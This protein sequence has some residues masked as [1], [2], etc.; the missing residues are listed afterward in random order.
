MQNAKK[1]SEFE[2]IGLKKQNYNPSYNRTE[3]IE[4]MKEVLKKYE[5]LAYNK[6]RKYN[7]AYN[8]Y[9]KLDIITTIPVIIITAF[10]GSINFSSTFSCDDNLSIMISS[11]NIFCASLLG[12]GRYFRFGDTKEKCRN[13]VI[14]F[15][16]MLNKIYVELSNIDENTEDEAIKKIINEVERYYDQIYLSSPMIPVF[17]NNKKFKKSNSDQSIFL[18]NSQLQAEKSENKSSS[19]EEI[20]NKV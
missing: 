17:I 10:T 16:K 13:S 8:Y 19:D 14:G 6:S 9:K 12:V 18:T 1:I 2:E 3:K 11:L 5:I 20:N 7:C 15:D 4:H